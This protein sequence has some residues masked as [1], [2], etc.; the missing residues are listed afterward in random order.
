MR[1]PHINSADEWYTYTY[2]P[3]LSKVG[4]AISTAATL[5]LSYYERVD[6]CYEG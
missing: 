2:T 1:K 6:A 4:G 3:P 5:V